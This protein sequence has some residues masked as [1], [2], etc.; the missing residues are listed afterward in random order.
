MATPDP[1]PWPAA[2]AQTIRDWATRL[3][4]P[5]AIDLVDQFQDW[6]GHPAEVNEVSG[7]WSPVA[8]RHITRSVDDLD[9]AT[10]NLTNYWEGRGADGFAGYSDNLR[11]QIGDTRDPIGQVADTLIASLD[12][13][14]EA[15]LTAVRLISDFAQQILEAVSSGLN[16]LGVVLGVLQAFVAAAEE[17][18]TSYINSVYEQTKTMRGLE[19]AASELGLPGAAPIGLGDPDEWMVTPAGDYDSP[20]PDAFDPPAPSEQGSNSTSPPA[21]GTPAPGAGGLP[22]H[23]GP[24]PTPPK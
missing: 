4:V 19:N 5:R 8:T 3:S 21:T 13:I 12:I 20:V 22:E 16:I 15:Y 2:Q 10:T 1:A 7:K 9:I 23:K 11:S 17:L 6:L 18:A 24:E 14:K